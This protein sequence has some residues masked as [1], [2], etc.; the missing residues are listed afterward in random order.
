MKK[1]IIAIIVVLL[2]VGGG[3]AAYNYYAVYTS[4]ERELLVAG[5]N[6]SELDSYT[7]E[8]EMDMDIQAMGEAATFYISVVTDYDKIGKAL[9]SDASIALNFEGMPIDIGVEIVYVND[10]L[11][12]KV[13]SL[14]ALITMFLPPEVDQLV[15]ENILLVEGLM[16]KGDDLLV[17][18]L[19]DNDVPAMSAED[20][21]AELEE[22]G[23]DV[24][25]EGV[26]SVVAT[27]S[28][29]LDGE[30]AKK[31]TLEMDSDK[32]IDFYYDLM[33]RYSIVEI[34]ADAAGEDVDVVREEMELAM[35]EAREEMYK[36]YEEMEVYAWVV[37]DYLVRMEVS[38]R[39]YIE[40]ESDY[41]D[42]S[43]IVS[44]SNFNESFEIDEPV[45]Y[46][47]TEELENLMES[48]LGPGVPMGM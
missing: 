13:S 26:I 45:D 1:T 2:L 14:P 11:Y 19:E 37:D 31:Y 36:A 38:F 42:M 33:E 44:Y 28:D 8:V 6:V 10:N 41:V 40:D 25:K 24:W 30:S 27:E 29:E 5:K 7:M 23:E 9:R 4:D 20:L 32:M 18:F 17:E 21:L 3:Y 34:M 12:A 48:I 47:T 16:E 15:G 46:I 35:E 22:L 39:D 43:M